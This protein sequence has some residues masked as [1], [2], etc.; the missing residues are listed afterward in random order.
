VHI[1]NAI[2]RHSIRDIAKAYGKELPENF[3]D[4]SREHL[5]RILIS[6][7][8]AHSSGRDVFG[9]TPEERARKFFE[10]SI[11]TYTWNDTLY[12]LLWKLENEV[13]KPKIRFEF[14]EQ[15]PTVFGHTRAH[16]DAVNNTAYIYPTNPFQDLISEYTHSKQFNDEFFPSVFSSL[17]GDLESGLTAVKKGM[18][19][20]EAYDSTQYVQKGSL[21]YNAHEQIQKVLEAALDGEEPK[22][23][24]LGQSSRKT[25][26]R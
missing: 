23:L 14:I 9:M 2:Y 11:P 24:V 20:R 19:F 21:E 15:G 10:R 8:K 12:H 26:R 22:E 1:E 6:C 18:T 7:Y 3:A 4:L 5:E 13:G 17:Q 16:Y 25:T